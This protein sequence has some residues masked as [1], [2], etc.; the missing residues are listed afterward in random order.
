LKTVLFG[1][2]EKT[3]SITSIYTTKLENLKNQI[4]RGKLGMPPTMVLI[5]RKNKNYLLSVENGST[6]RDIYKRISL[7]GKIK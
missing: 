6:L 2:L 1:L 3:A 4:T 5:R 7:D